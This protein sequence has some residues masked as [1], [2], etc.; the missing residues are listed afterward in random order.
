MIGVA[1]RPGERDIVAEFFE[2]FKT[3]WEFFRIDRQ[4]DVLIC[5]DDRPRDAVASL[6]LHYSAVCAHGN[7]EPEVVCRSRPSGATILYAGRRLP[8]Y[9]NVAT[10]PISGFSVLMDEATREPAAFKSGSN[11]RTILRIGYDLFQEVRSLLKIGQPSANA[12]IPTLELHIALLRDLIT[13]AGIPIVEIPSVPDGYNLIACLTHDVDQPMLR[14]HCCDHTM[15]GFLYRATIGS[16]V[17]VCRGWKPLKS[18]G[19]NL[20]AVCKLPFIYLGM[21]EDIWGRFDR[22]VEMEN[23]LGSTFFVIPRKNDPGIS[24]D[25]SIAPMRAS[26]YEIADIKPQIE[27]ISLSGNEIGL[28]G[29]GAWADDVKAREEYQEI[30]QVV[31]ETAV[32]VRMHWLYYN[33]KSPAILDRA[34]FSYDSTVGYNETVGYR[35]GT[36]QAYK[37]LESSN[38]LELPLQVMDTALFFPAYL[39][40]SEME[41]GRV[42]SKLIDGVVQFGGAL[43]VN[44]HDRSIAP[45]RL[46]DDFYLKLL[47]ELKNRSA[48]CPTA[49]QAVSWFRKRRSAILT[50]VRGEGGTLQ[51]KISGN[52][53][54]DLPG[55]RI[56]VYRPGRWDLCGTT[57]PDGSVGF[58]DVCLQEN[59][60]T[61]VA[62]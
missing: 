8:I 18:A 51:V 41:A 48:W 47:R 50:A 13:S 21:M 37:P 59:T 55:L 44:W 58:K 11:D 22:Y 36:A 33:D 38:L 40:L 53:G 16:I 20:A 1:I 39:N 49:F 10:F 15:F 35:A 34:G 57:P 26:R 17:N 12:G 7:T 52:T 56:R 28:H 62:F 61:T 45:E 42:V 43:T 27:K 60:N 24:P 46:W 5:T 29:I 4:Y 9:G 19:I 32:G 2:L 31:G 3:P 6:T 54:H 25:G 14:S 30:F 23:G